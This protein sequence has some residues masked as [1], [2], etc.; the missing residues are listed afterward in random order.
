MLNRE[1]TS[2]NFSVFDMTRVQTTDLSHSEQ[3]LCELSNSCC[4]AFN[5][6]ITRLSD[7][8]ET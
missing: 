3:V 7:E 8:E 4:S 2:A 1:A 5:F 6:I